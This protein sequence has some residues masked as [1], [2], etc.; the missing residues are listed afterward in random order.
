MWAFPRPKTVEKLRRD[1]RVEIEVIQR[2]K[3]GSR[4][5]VLSKITQLY[6]KDG[7]PAGTV[8]INRDITEIKRKQEVLIKS[9]QHD[10][11]LAELTSRLLECDNIEIILQDI[12]RSVMLYLN[13]DIFMTFLTDP[14]NTE[15]RLHSSS[16]LPESETEMRQ[17]IAFGHKLGGEAAQNKRRIIRGDLVKSRQAAPGTPAPDGLAAYVCYPLIS[18]DKILGT[19]GFGSK[20]QAFF[21]DDELSFISVI[22]NDISIAMSRIAVIRALAE[23]EERAQVLVKRLKTADRNK[24]DFLN[25]LSHELRNPL[26]TIVAAFRCWKCPTRQNAAKSW[27]PEIPD[28][29][30]VPAGGR[31][32]GPDAHDK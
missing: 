17:W 1:G 27:R 30:A 25:S 4:L 3:D 22:S 20:K 19:V 16:G 5:N 21:T 29:A 23:S 32:A 9:R 24:N 10:K 26:A 28:G 13:F 8:G 15:L 31:P 2:R 12:C 7:R 18:K 11:M 14:E 6:D